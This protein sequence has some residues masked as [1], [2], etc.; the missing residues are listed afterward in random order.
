MA[1]PASGAPRAGLATSAFKW[2]RLGSQRLFRIVCRAAFWSNYNRTFRKAVVWHMVHPL[3]STDEQFPLIFHH[4]G[5]LLF[6]EFKCSTVSEGSLCSLSCWLLSFSW[7]IFLWSSIF[8]YF[9]QHKKWPR[10]RVMETCAV[11]A[12]DLDLILE[13]TDIPWL[14]GGFSQDPLVPASPI[15][16]TYMSHLYLHPALISH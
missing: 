13:F 1:G 10:P 11:G 12:L 8:L 15:C 4:L 7:F 3:C 14:P 9:L 6:S 16:R 5:I 2:I